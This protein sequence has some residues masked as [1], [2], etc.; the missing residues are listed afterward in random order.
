MTWA[1]AEA[2]AGGESQRYAILPSTAT[3]VVSA[4]KITT[5]CMLSRA[6]GN[7]VISARTIPASCR[8]PPVCNSSLICAYDISFSMLCSEILAKLNRRPPLGASGNSTCTC[9][10]SLHCPP[11]MISRRSLPAIWRL[12]SLGVHS[13]P[14]YTATDCSCPAMLSVNS[15]GMAFSGQT[16]GRWNSSCSAAETVP[17]WPSTLPSASSRW[18]TAGGEST[19]AVPLPGR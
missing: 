5:P 17:P 13:L 9:R 1:V 15:V 2:G 6:C 3:L 10:P 16:A 14:G 8:S 18:P 19:S 7:P 12:Y 4:W 11:S